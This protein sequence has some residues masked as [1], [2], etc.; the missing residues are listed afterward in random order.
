MFRTPGWRSAYVYLGLHAHT[1]TPIRRDCFNLC[2]PTNLPKCGSYFFC[3]SLLF[4]NEMSL[5]VNNATLLL[6]FIG[7]FS[8][9]SSEILLCIIIF[10]HLVNPLKF[11][12]L[13]PTLIYSWR[14]IALLCSVGSMLCSSSIYQKF[15][16]VWGMVLLCCMWSKARVGLLQGD[17]MTELQMYTI[18][19]DMILHIT[20]FITV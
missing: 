9:I 13:I 7:N 17:R 12:L 18:M 19:H 11:Y 8:G 2:L 5:I 14:Y 16:F 3:L 10:A 15:T 20:A 4:L 1:P 6:V